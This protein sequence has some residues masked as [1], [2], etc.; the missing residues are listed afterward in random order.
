MAVNPRFIFEFDG[1]PVTEPKGWDTFAHEINRTDEL[2]YALLED[3]GS[4]TLEFYADAY[5]YLSNERAEGYC[6]AVSLTIKEDCTQSGNY[7]TKVTGTIYLTDVEFDRTNCA[8]R[9]KI[10]DDS[11]FALI[12]NNKSI[13]VAINVGKTKNGEDLTD[14]ERYDITMFDPCTGNTVAGRT[15]MAY[16]A[17][18]VGAYLIS[19]LTDNQVSFRSTLLDSLGDWE[20]LFLASGEMIRNNG[21]GSETL[22]TTWDNFISEIGKKVPLYYEIDTSG[23]TPVL[24]LEARR[25][26]LEDTTILTC[27]DVDK[28]LEAVDPSKVYAAVRFGSGSVIESEGCGVTN[29]PAFP[30]QIDFVGCKE[31]EFHTQGQ[32]N[33]DA[34]LDLSGDWNVSSNVIEQVFLAFSEDYDGEVC[35]LHVENIDTALFTADAIVT[36]FFSTANPVVYNAE[37][38]N[39]KVAV[40]F[41]DQIHNTL[42]KYLEPATLGFKAQATGAEVYTIPPTSSVNYTTIYEPF[43]FGQDYTVGSVD[44]YDLA[45]D[46]G[47][48]SV[49]GALITQANSRFTA[50]SSLSYSSWYKFR[51]NIGVLS[52]TGFPST[53]AGIIAVTFVKYDIL[54]NLIDEYDVIKTYQN[55]GVEYNQV[56]DS[57]DINLLSGEYVQ[58]RISTNGCT[59]ILGTSVPNYEPTYFELVSYRAGG[60]FQDIDK[61]DFINTLYKFRYPMTSSEFDLVRANKRGKVAFTSQ[62]FSG[63]GWIK[64]LKY[65][66][67]GQSQGMAEFTLI[68]DGN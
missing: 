23:A 53:I 1:N 26:G 49:Q 52:V 31:E 35:F 5:Q 4:N 41:Y 27:P 21:D 16:R 24:V 42:V 61:A 7:K 32:C 56:F 9:T 58:V 30:D 37:L 43:A 3:I 66:P 13:E 17:V 28:V 54:N 64:N 15:A 44:G 38:F 47:N 10:T 68:T 55:I 51:V 20:G 22:T 14:I 33:I 67:A 40:R 19:F 50:P 11:F 8:A 36:Q 60:I 57:P 63:S 65:Y 39:Q 59:P 46:Y 62:N 29:E 2:P 18:D 48:G 12:K 25:D 34:K 45:N 6:N